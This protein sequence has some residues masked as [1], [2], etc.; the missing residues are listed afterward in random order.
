M[1]E[2]TNRR[3]NSF[4]PE[5]LTDEQVTSIEASVDKFFLTVAEGWAKVDNKLQYLES[6]V[7]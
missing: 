6:V 1:N 7:R 3:L 2:H 5:F 4:P